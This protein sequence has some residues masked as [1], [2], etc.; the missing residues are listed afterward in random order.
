MTNLA[1]YYQDVEKD[2][3][4]MKKYYLMA[5][6]L[7]NLL[8]MNNLANYYQYAEKDYALMKKYYLMA[9]ESRKCGRND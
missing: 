5:I 9:I 2:Y 1:N 6:D 3:A 7:G 4:L 8:A